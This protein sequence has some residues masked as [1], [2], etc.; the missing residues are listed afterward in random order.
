MRVL[1][2]VL[3]RF[4]IRSKGVVL[5]MRYISMFVLLLAC[6]FVRVGCVMEGASDQDL[7][8]EE[9]D[10]ASQEQDLVGSASPQALKWTLF[11]AESCRDICGANSTGCSC[12][13]WVPGC[14]AN[15]AGKT[16]GS[17]NARCWSVGS[18]TVKQY[19]CR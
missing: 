12:R 5:M 13:S 2:S 15:P 19:V 9:V 3:P 1:Q 16:C 18:T 14:P 10:V 4:R 6:M 17:A 7:T 8:S 11:T